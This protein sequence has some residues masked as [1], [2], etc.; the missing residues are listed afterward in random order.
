MG[1]AI[2]RTRGGDG[3][4]T[5]YERRLALH[6]MVQPVIGHALL[7]DPL[8]LGSGFLARCLVCNP[9]SAIGGRP[10]EKSRQTPWAVVG[11][12]TR[13]AAILNTPLPID[14]ET[15]GLKTRL[16]KLSKGAREMLIAY[17]DE[18]E[19]AQAKGQRFESIR[20]YAS[21]SAEQ[22][23]RIA[24]VLTMWHDLKATEVTA[25][26]MLDGITLARYYLNE[27][28][29]L[30]NASSVSQDLQDAEELR[31]WLVERS[32]KAEISSRELKQFCPNRLRANNPARMA[33]I[34]CL[35]DHEW[36]LPIEPEKRWKVVRG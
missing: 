19:F 11:Y 4:I 23:C 27:A 33:A 36:L 6:L 22:A 9:P 8:A 30:A 7:S 35:V 3:N 24:G 34:A 32:G 12:V 26:L 25:D 13:M 14:P 29:R 21:K 15:G 18:V 16:L 2:K 31:S 17:S 20:S 28:A 1:E 10:H 5:L